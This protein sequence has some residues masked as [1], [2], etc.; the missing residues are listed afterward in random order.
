MNCENIPLL[1][2]QNIINCEYYTLSKKNIISSAFGELSAI[3]LDNTNYILFATNKLQG[4][5][6]F[7]IKIDEQSQTKSNI[8]I[9]D[10]L[11]LQNKNIKLHLDSNHKICINDNIISNTKLCKNQWHHIALN[12]ANNSEKELELEFELFINGNLEILY[13]L[14]MENSTNTNTHTN[15]TKMEVDADIN[16][17][18]N[19]CKFYIADFIFYGKT[20][21]QTQIIQY[22]LQQKKQPSFTI[23][24]TNEEG[25]I[26]VIGDKNNIRISNDYGTT[27]STIDTKLPIDT[28]QQYE[29]N[30]CVLTQKNNISVFPT[31]EKDWNTP[32][33]TE[34]LNDTIIS[35]V[36]SKN[37]KELFF[38]LENGNVLFLP[39]KNYINN[40]TAK[41][42]IWN[43]FAILGKEKNNY[44]ITN[45]TIYL[46]TA[47]NNSLK[48]KPLFSLDV[49]ETKY[50]S[51]IASTIDGE[52][53]FA[54]CYNGYIYASL[55]G[56]TNWHISLNVV[57]KWS[58]IEMSNSGQ[59]ISATIDE[60]S[61]YH[62]YNCGETWTE[63]ANVPKTKWKKLVMNGNGEH[64]Y[65]I[66]SNLGFYKSVLFSNSN[67]LPQKKYSIEEWIK[68]GK[69]PKELLTLGFTVE[70]QLEANINVEDMFKDGFTVNQLIEG[71]V[72]KLL[73]ANLGYTLQQLK[74]GG[75]TTKQL[76]NAGYT[77]NQL[78]EVG[79]T[80][81]SVAVSGFTVAELK[82]GGMTA[83]DLYSL[84]YN[85]A[86]LLD[87]GFTKKEVATS[88][89]NIVMLKVNDYTC[90][91]LLDAGFTMTEL[92]NAGFHL[93][94]T[95][96][97][98]ICDNYEQK[99]TIEE[100]VETIEFEPPIKQQEETINKECECECEIK[101][102]NN[103][104]NN[105]EK[106]ILATTISSK[107]NIEELKKLG[108]FT[109]DD[110][111]KFQYSAY[112]LRTVGKYSA[113][114][115]YKSGYYSAKDLKQ[116][117]YLP[118]VII[119]LEKNTSLL[120]KLGYSINQ[121]LTYG[122]TPK[123][124]VN[125][126][127]QLAELRK[128]NSYIFNASFL[129]QEINCSA[130]ELREAGFTINDVENYIPPY[131]IL[132]IA[133]SG[134]S[135][136]NLCK[137]NSL[138][139][140]H[141][142]AYRHRHHQLTANILY[143][144]NFAINELKNYPKY[145]AEKDIITAG[146]SICN[147]YQ[148]GY[149]INTLLQ[150][151]TKKQLIKGF[152]NFPSNLNL[153]EFTF[154]A[155]ELYEEGFTIQQLKINNYNDE[156]IINA[157]YNLQQLNE[158]NYK[159]IQIY[160][161]SSNKNN[162]TTQ[163]I[164]CCH[165]TLDEIL[166]AKMNVAELK[167]HNIT[168]KQ[169]QK[170]GYSIVELQEAKYIANEIINAGYSI[171][172]LISFGNYSVFDIIKWN[173]EFILQ[174]YIECAEAG[175]FSVEEIVIAN[176][177]LELELELETNSNSN[178]KFCWNI[179]E[180]KMAKITV[181]Q[182]KQANY[183]AKELLNGGYS[184]ECLV[185][186]GFSAK[187]LFEA[188]CNIETVKQYFSPQELYL[189][190]YDLDIILQQN[191]PL[192]T[193]L[194]V[195]VHLL[196]KYYDDVLLEEFGFY[197][198]TNKEKELCLNSC[199]NNSVSDCDIKDICF[200][201]DVLRIIVA[202]I[203]FDDENNKIIYNKFS[204]NQSPY[205]F[206]TSINTGNNEENI[207]LSKSILS[208][209]NISLQQKGNFIQLIRGIGRGRGTEKNE[210]ITIPYYFD[211][212]SKPKSP[213]LLFATF[214]E[215]I[216]NTIV[217]SFLHDVNDCKYMYSIDDKEYQNISY[218]KDAKIYISYVDMEQDK[219]HLLQIIAINQ[220]GIR[221]VPSNTLQISAKK[222]PTTPIIIS[223][224]PTNCGATVYFAVSETTPINYIKYRINGKNEYFAMTCE[225]PLSLCHLTNG[226]EYTIELKCGN[227]FGESCYSIISTSS[228]F[229]PHTV[230]D[231]PKIKKINCCKNNIE[232]DFDLNNDNGS[233]IQ[234]LLFCIKDIGNGN[235]QFLTQNIT[236]PFIIANS[237]FTKGET[238][239]VILQS[240]NKAGYSLQSNIC[241]FV[242]G[243]PT[244]IPSIIDVIV[245]NGYFIATLDDA[246]DNDNDDDNNNE[247]MKTTI[248]NYLCWVFDNDGL[249]VKQLK[250]D[251]NKTS[252]TK[253]IVD[254]LT[255]GKKYSFEIKS[256]NNYGSSTFSTIFDNICPMK[257][258]EPITIKD[259][260]MIADET[261]IEI[262]KAKITLN[263][264]SNGGSPITKYY[265]SFATLTTKQ[266]IL[267]DN[268]DWIE[269]TTIYN[270]NIQTEV[271]GLQTNT[272]YKFWFKC[273]NEVGE[274][275]PT[276]SKIIF[277][278]I[279]PPNN[280]IIQS[281][282][283]N[284]S[285]ITVYFDEPNLN[286]CNKIDHYYY[287]LDG[288]ISFECATNELPLIIP[289][290]K[291]NKNYKLQIIANTIAGNS[292]A[293][294]YNKI[295][296]YQY[297]PPYPPLLKNIEAQNGKLE[298]HFN[299]SNTRNAPITKLFYSLDG[300]ITFAEFNR[301]GISSPQVIEN[302]TNGIE[303]NIALMNGSCIGN[304]TISNVVCAIPIYDVPNPPFFVA[305]GGNGSI[306][307]QWK[308]PK[309]N[310][311]T[312]QSYQLFVAC[313]D[314][315]ICYQQCFDNNVFFATVDGLTNGQEYTIQMQ[316]SNEIGHS[317]MTEKTIVKPIYEKPTKP[318]ICNIYLQQEKIAKIKYKPS[319]PNG[320][321]LKTHYYSIDDGKHWIN[322]NDVCG[323]FF[324][325][326][327]QKNTYKLIMI[328]ENELGFSAISVGKL[329]TVK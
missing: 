100:T 106:I 173:N 208:Q 270:D 68:E 186:G 7:W 282:I 295:L 130:K 33:M 248:E 67:P 141:S 151:F 293:T 129:K 329:F 231:T 190:G 93:T 148:S 134:F 296:H 316:C 71:G 314:G 309:C 51:S 302:L 23:L 114:Q 56:G 32:P 127:F 233:K 183:I 194:F 321:T 22:I 13:Q 78:L 292:I 184:I 250:M 271:L 217:V 259:I 294:N 131:T 254:G 234:E 235:T 213:I 170:K 89:F 9:F 167:Q 223:S 15:T 66:S 161:H 54:T 301:N 145:F 108:N 214:D 306:K 79:F 126:G 279:K 178:S 227:A 86:E 157:G 166:D 168:A 210:K 38:E 328:G 285:N 241:E 160:K 70:Q 59:Y 226:K 230:P 187:D 39:N 255:N 159:P 40:N 175:L 3:I 320:G 202:K 120:Q 34:Q 55:D 154:E 101:T 189:G 156:E 303:Y 98:N 94:T 99:M 10:A 82:N 272:N 253:I 52:Y 322:T 83:F 304:S 218:L 65:A 80:K 251:K 18:S 185:S 133:Q 267:M 278:N 244:I 41:K 103:N 123:M 229:V 232:I 274:T 152:L 283:I 199:N 236:T 47:K 104:N 163:L 12:V 73:I 60:G 37:R 312:I 85:I 147:L 288:G 117:G 5:F 111:F 26:V 257:C 77:A 195:D 107:N 61:I 122:H 95:T 287:S 139:H 149:S 53:I 2:S 158:A 245:G 135:L 35:S 19:N 28:L 96:T 221:S 153:K 249:C 74:N 169:L 325:Y 92:M 206:A 196:Q 112:Y 247:K 201:G 327:L 192:E 176:K 219:D 62:S 243:I 116:G 58:N 155:K 315:I 14:Q 262:C 258:P 4:C 144:S 240:K 124:V 162:L 310:G 171:A 268:L 305:T 266:K 238:Y 275:Q 30:L 179:A 323:E 300:G 25:N 125:A 121:L 276:E 110:I 102:E 143:Q 188:N 220:M 297:L 84:G 198:Q 246:N 17:N 128:A 113:S 222:I 138:Q 205:Y 150:Y 318:I 87:A 132:E 239:K 197:L 118:S 280:V 299:Q 24:S 48:I 76:K 57:A 307:V 326:N 311:S 182:L 119:G 317:L 174:Q 209:L 115:L 252:Q 165:F 216:N 90:D 6:S 31:L 45:D 69:T 97:N 44:G 36:L 269:I 200:E 191:Y 215:K 16:D 21:T 29:D 137:L 263:V 286:G 105:N 284:K 211:D 308:Q 177:K 75:L 11:I 291:P 193:L 298:V 181:P 49:N 142:Q 224:K 319:I 204:I 228:T 136:N 27:F 42:I 91:E 81:T 212:L 264:P 20:Q 277:C 1:I 172:N 180:L 242:F 50:F 324:I 203:D 225:S 63:N 46:I 146:Y 140:P 88:G 64:Q 260:K 256:A 237:N 281:A 207:I 289:N 313:N 8:I 164:E 290:I 261:N 109:D 273:K 43:G 72:S 265:Y